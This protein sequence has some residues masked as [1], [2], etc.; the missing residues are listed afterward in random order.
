MKIGSAWLSLCGP[1]I[2]AL[3]CSKAGKNQRPFENAAPPAPG[4]IGASWAGQCRA[5]SQKE[6]LIFDILAPVALSQH[7]IAG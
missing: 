6:F 7:A 5:G 2:P 3:T 4:S 1:G